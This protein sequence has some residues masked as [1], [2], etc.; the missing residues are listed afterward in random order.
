MAQ[1]VMIQPN[2][3]LTGS[4]VRMVPLGVLY[5]SSRVVT[6]TELDLTILD[7]RAEPNRWQDNLGKLLGEETRIVGFSVMSGASIDD[8]L[9]MSTW[10][11]QHWPHIK[12]VWGGPHPTFSPDDILEEPL[13]DYVISG[14]GRDA[15]FSLVQHL[16]E[17]RDARL[18]ETINGLGWRD[19]S[20][21][22]RRNPPETEFE[23]LDYKAI[24]YHLI[25]DYSIYRH[26]DAVNVACCIR[27]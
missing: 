19:G 15:F 26:I 22:S 7:V 21:T 12:I 24:P 2:T 20:G 11:K 1:I 14:Y 4:F 6:E 17:L 18:P 27:S 13:I 10:V 25:E 16:F 8:S 9:T 5:A 23:F 3:S